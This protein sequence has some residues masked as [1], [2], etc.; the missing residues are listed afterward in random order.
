MCR[1]PLR[2]LLN[3]ESRYAWTLTEADRHLPFK[4]PICDDKMMIV[5]YQ[6]K[7][8]C[9]R[10]Y[11]YTAHGGEGETERHLEMKKYVFTQGVKLGYECELEVRMQANGSINIADVV[12][13]KNPQ[14]TKGFV[15]E[16]QHS[17]ITKK[18]IEKR[19]QTYY[20][21]GFSPIWVFDY[22]YTFTDICIRYNEGFNI[23]DQGYR[24]EVKLLDLINGAYK[25][26]KPENIIIYPIWWIILY[27]PPKTEAITPAPKYR[28]PYKPRT[29]FSRIRTIIQ[30]KKQAK[31]ITPPSYIKAQALLKDGPI[32]TIDFY[33]KMENLGVPWKDTHDLFCMQE[34]RLRIINFFE[35]E[36]AH[37]GGFV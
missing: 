12:I 2:A 24:K 23:L 3:N 4:C 27:G 7:Q 15:F 13:Y 36:L 29:Q 17:P 20:K 25:K 30:I 1:M 5:L 26:R 22:D 33:I 21:N 16:C 11:T 8:K 10:H 37:N 34:S 9:F 31:L 35:V 6:K 19:N 28:P 18:E 32:K 14:K